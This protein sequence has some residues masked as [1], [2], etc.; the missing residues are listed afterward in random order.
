MKKVKP[1]LIKKVVWKWE[2]GVY[3]AFCPYCG[4]PAYEKDG[5]CFCHKP[6]I[7][8]EGDHQPI[9]ITQGE[10]TIVQSTN[11]HIMLYKNGSVIMHGACY[12]KLSEEELLAEIERVKNLEH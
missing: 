3:L 4:E 2:Y 6:Y 7:W 12:K 10:Y 5:C 8:V 1:E 9:K 11:N